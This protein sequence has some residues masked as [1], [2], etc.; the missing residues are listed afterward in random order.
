M[1]KR[2]RQGLGEEADGA[3]QK[4][5]YRISRNLPRV[6]AGL[7][8]HVRRPEETDLPI[9]TRSVSEERANSAIASLTLRVT[10]FLPVA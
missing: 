1:T 10:L 7:M 9:V 5:D 2:R 3:E 6:Q 4:S 8:T